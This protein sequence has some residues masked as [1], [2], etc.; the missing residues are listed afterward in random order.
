MLFEVLFCRVANLLAYEDKSV[1]RKQ[2]QNCIVIVVLVD[3][4]ILF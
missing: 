1:V 2:Q 4:L 3:L